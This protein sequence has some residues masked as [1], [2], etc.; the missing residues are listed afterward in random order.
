MG[1]ISEETRRAEREHFESVIRAFLWYR[2]HGLEV[3]KKAEVRPP[4]PRLCPRPAA[5]RAG[6]ALHAREGARQTRASQGRLRRERGRR[7]RGRPCPI[8]QGSADPC[9][10]GVLLARRLRG[11]TTRRALPAEAERARAGGWGGGAGR[12]SD[13]LLGRRLA[14]QGFRRHIKT[15]SRTCQVR[16]RSNSVR[17]SRAALLPCPV[18]RRAC[19]RRSVTGSGVMMRCVVRK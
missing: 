1:G 19:D 4:A 5:P 17:D 16:A 9:S 14:T 12:G 3:I 10:A 2:E 8:T 13:A 18:P 15:C 6:T 11:A 7:R